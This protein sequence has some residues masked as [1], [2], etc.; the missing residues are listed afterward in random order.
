MHPLLEKTL[1]TGVYATTTGDEIKILG[2][3]PKEQCEF[4]QKIIADNHFKSSIEIGFAN[5]I[6]ALAITEA[7]TNNGGSHVE[8]DKFQTTDWHGMGLDL[9][10]QAG[11]SIEFHEDFSYAVL[12]KLLEQGR[13]FDF[14]Y[15]DST[16]LFDYMI[17]D[18]FYL[19]K[20]LEVNGI[21]VIDDAYHSGISK[22]LR[23]VLQLPTYKVYAVFP[24]NAEQLTTKKKFAFTTLKHLPKK[25]MYI[26]EEVLKSRKDLGIAGRCVALVKT[27]DDNRNY[28]WH[29]AF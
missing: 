5:G 24:G 20:M 2:E 27:G 9:I 28:D 22:M 13:R 15:V 6:S 10:K 19:D 23:F 17:V 12:P 4:L 7:I 26:R 16:K 3:T 14:A 25:E 11:Y 1:N 29:K 8:I 18:F 21:F